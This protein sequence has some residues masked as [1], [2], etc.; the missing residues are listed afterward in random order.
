VFF[1]PVGDALVG[2]QREIPGRGEAVQT[3]YYIV[4]DADPRVGLVEDVNA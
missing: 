1:R 2:Q 3:D 4:D